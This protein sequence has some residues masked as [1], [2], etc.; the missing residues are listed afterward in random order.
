MDSSYME[1]VHLLNIPAFVEGS[2][3]SMMSYICSLVIIQC[4]I[5]CE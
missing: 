4:F 1:K 5:P 3:L 2:V